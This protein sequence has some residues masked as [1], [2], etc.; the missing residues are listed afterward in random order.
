VA[1][2]YQIPP[3]PQS[4]VSVYDDVDSL[5]QFIAS[6]NEAPLANADE[7]QIN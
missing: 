5:L 7:P 1:A 6:E 2:P 3:Q 4:H